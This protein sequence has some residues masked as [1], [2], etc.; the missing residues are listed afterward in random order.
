MLI[1]RKFYKSELSDM[2][3]KVLDI[4]RFIQPFNPFPSAELVNK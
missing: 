3:F 2:L 4:Q 1:V